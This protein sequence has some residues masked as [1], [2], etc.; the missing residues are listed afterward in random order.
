MIVTC[1]TV[2]LEIERRLSQLEQQAVKRHKTAF[3]E[4]PLPLAD[5]EML[6]QAA[7]QYPKHMLCAY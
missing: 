1:C 6:H 7:V 4:T 2:N 5:G 3:T